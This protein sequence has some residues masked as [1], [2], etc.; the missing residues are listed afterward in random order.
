MATNNPSIQQLKRALTIS[1]Q[2]EKLQ[3][4][5]ASILGSAAPASAP[6]TI[7]TKPA[8]AGARTL[9]PEAR[10]KIAAAA[11]ARW[12]R[13]KGTAPSAASKP[14]AAPKKKGGLTP[15]GRAKLAASMK[16]RWAA[17]RKGA[18]APTKPSAA[19]AAPKKAAAPADGGKR[20]ISPEAR[21][22]MIEGAKRR[23]ASKKN[24]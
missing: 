8:K 3:G 13:A 4:E 14:A 11:R 24:G 15:E 22:R 19:K 17:R 16:A 2:I 10:E 6:K 7:A 1:E 5:L 9:S 12:A 18:P 21:A 20:T 23:W